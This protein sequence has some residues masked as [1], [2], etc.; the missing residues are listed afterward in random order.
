[1]AVQAPVTCAFYD[2]PCGANWLVI[3]LESFGSWLYQLFLDGAA[4]LIDVIPVPDFLLNLQTVNMPSGVAFFV[5]PFEVE[6]GI[7]IIVGAYIARFIVRR[8][9]LIG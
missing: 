4:S 8:I 5:A 3:Q 2:I 9:P 1:M 6:F 7:G